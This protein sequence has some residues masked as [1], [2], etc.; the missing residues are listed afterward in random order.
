LPLN[1]NCFA[2]KYYRTRNMNRQ[3][4]PEKQL[5][6]LIE[7]PNSPR[8]LHSASL[9]YHSLSFLTL[10]GLQAWIL[11]LENNL[12]ALFKDGRIYQVDVKTV[13]QFLKLCV[14]LF[15]VYFIVNL[16][17]SVIGLRKDLNLRGKFEKKAALEGEGTKSLLK[18]LT[19]YLEKARERDLFKMGR[20]LPLETANTVNK[21]PSARIIEA[22]KD[23]RLVGISWSNDPDVM[24]EDTANQRTLFLKRGQTFANNVKLNAVYKDKVTLGFEGEEVE[25]R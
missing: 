15:G 25:L 7:K 14:I 11:F 21:G 22:T 4:T 24:I 9:K 16:T 8:A 12:R 19:Y 17:V 20:K 5:L 6:N 18:S 10:A 1:W 2:R 13:N 3:N 23:F